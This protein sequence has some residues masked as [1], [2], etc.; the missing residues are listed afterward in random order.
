M[1]RAAGRSRASELIDRAKA[2][3]SL[4]DFGDDGFREGLEILVASADAEAR[5]TET[6]RAAFDGQI[7]GFLGQRLQVEDWYARHPEID[8]Q[9]IT[10]PLIGLGLPRTGSTALSCLLAE[11]PAVRFIRTWEGITPCPPPR[12]ETEHTDPRI[13]IAE[14]S[15]ARRNVLFPRM[16]IMLPSTATGPTECQTFMGHDFKSQLFQ[17]FARIPTYTDWLNYRADLVPTYRYVKR[18]LKLLQW[19]CPPTRWRLKNPSHSMFITA[20]DEVFP[21]ARYWMTHRDIGAVV[22]S[23]CDVYYEL[24]KAYSDEVDTRFLGEQNS[25]WTE[26]GLRRVIAFRDAGND[27]RFFDIHFA[28]FQKDPFPILEKLYAFLGEGLTAETRARMQAWREAM[29]RDKHGA[30][31]HDPAA[32]GIDLA[33]LRQRFGFYAERFDVAPAA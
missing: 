27:D 20:L 14:E 25:A 33:A 23:V 12:K 31:P 3:V 8:E 21:D 18:V 11:D 4:E 19:R 22:P 7:I 5:F 26:L 10:A 15:M 1:T 6:G 30:A 17:A 9:E 16:K 24:S 32:F 2:A 28:P 29:P 13:A